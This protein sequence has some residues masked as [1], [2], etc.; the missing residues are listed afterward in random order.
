LKERKRESKS[1]DGLLRKSSL[2]S[3]IVSKKTLGETAASRGNSRKKPA[4]L[5]QTEIGKN[6]AVRQ[7]WKTSGGE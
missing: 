1:R 4:T 6:K 7:T 2:A 5:T 3:E